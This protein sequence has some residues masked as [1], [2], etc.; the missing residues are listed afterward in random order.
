MFVTYFGPQNGEANVINKCKLNY[1][2]LKLRILI[3]YHDSYDTSLKKLEH[4]ISA[5]HSCNTLKCVCDTLTGLKKFQNMD[6]TR[7]KRERER[8]R[9]KDRK[10]DREK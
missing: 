7:R 10:R 8:E 1:A 9:K 3:K 2:M 4:F 6:P 5:L